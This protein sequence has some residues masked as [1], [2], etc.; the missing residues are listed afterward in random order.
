MFDSNLA[1]TIP[2]QTGNLVALTSLELSGNNLT[3]SIPRELGNLAN[4]QILTVDD[5]KFDTGT[6]V[7]QEICDLGLS[8]FS[9]DCFD[10]YFVVCHCC[11][12][13]GDQV[14]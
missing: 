11:N 14:A 13:C 3:D 2:T 9:T 1:G 5:N 6:T 8:P 10:N 12:D 7:P 4:L